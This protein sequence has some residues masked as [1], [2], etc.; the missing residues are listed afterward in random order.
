MRAKMTV[1]G[2]ELGQFEVFFDSECPL[3]RR[4]VDFLKWM[5]R[6]GRIRFTDIAADDFCESEVGLS[7]EQLM[8]EIHGR[9]ANG[10]WIK[11]FEVF[12]RMYDAIGWGP[13]VALTRWPMLKH[14][15]EKAYQWFARNRLRLTGRSSRSTDKEFVRSRFH[16]DSNNWRRSFRFGH[17]P[18]FVPGA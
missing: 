6:E 14:L 10:E 18:P 17:R 2:R 4:E 15:I 8:S 5:D 1:F 12:R 13:V 16:E 11:G 9:D 3:C 7:F